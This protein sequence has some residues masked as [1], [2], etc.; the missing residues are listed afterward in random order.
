M[1]VAGQEIR[2][3]NVSPQ[4]DAVSSTLASIQSET[5]AC[6]NTCTYILNARKQAPICLCLYIYVL[7][8]HMHTYMHTYF[9]NHNS[10][11]CHKCR[12]YPFM[13]KDSDG[14]YCI[15]PD[16]CFCT[17]GWSGSLCEI[18]ISIINTS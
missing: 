15:E 12:L 17:S 11:F 5:S 16:E 8:E 18:G 6:I 7:A 4:V 10:K 2:V 13:N 3:I 1:K 9:Y 14:G